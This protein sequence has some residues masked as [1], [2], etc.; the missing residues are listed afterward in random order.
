MKI[1]VFG[2]FSSMQESE[3]IKILNSLQSDSKRPHE[4]DI[5]NYL[6]GGKQVFST[7]GLARDVLSQN[8]VVIGPPDIF[9]DGAWAWS[10]EL[11]YYIGQYHIS[12]PNALLKRME[13]LQWHCPNVD[14]FDGL[15]FSNLVG[16][17][18]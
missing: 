17:V 16:E 15:D 3:S 12:I 8:R 9:T 13:Q 1:Q 4:D 6:R 11:L 14:S 7:P 10:V 5:L 18:K 2:I